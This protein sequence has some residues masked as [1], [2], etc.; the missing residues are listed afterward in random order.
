LSNLECTLKCLSIWRSFFQVHVQIINNDQHTLFAQMIIIANLIVIN[1][2]ASWEFDT[3][4]LGTYTM[5][6]PLDWVCFSMCKQGN[7]PFACG[8]LVVLLSTMWIITWT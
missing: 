5:L 7:F 6:C 4:A 2:C 1:Y 3:Q 8:S